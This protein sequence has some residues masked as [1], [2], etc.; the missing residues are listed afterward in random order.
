[1]KWLIGLIEQEPVMFQ[2]VIQTF[3]PVI[4]A[5]GLVSLSGESVSAIFA[6]TAAILTFV[7]RKQV[8]PVARSRDS[9]SD[10]GAL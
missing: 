9:A 7:T 1:M 2:G 8:A 10:K 3:I 4:V 6:C 5:L